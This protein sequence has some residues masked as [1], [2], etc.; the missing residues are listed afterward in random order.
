MAPFTPEPKTIWTSSR[1]F[2]FTVAGIAIAAGLW[3]VSRDNYLLFHT[4][5]E[6]FTV[7]VSFSIFMI[8]YNTRR[9]LRNNY[10]VLIGAALLFVGVVD[11]LHALTY[12]GMG[13][14]P[15]E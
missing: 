14:F 8:V 5:A 11:L 13:V 3:V 12:E 15:G 9:F 2:V 4:L 7:A 1:P 10:L 6:M